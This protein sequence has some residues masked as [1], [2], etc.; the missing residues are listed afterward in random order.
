M[1]CACIRSQCKNGR[2][3]RKSGP[4][5]IDRAG[6]PDT[7]ID[8]GAS[9]LQENGDMLTMPLNQGLAPDSVS[10]PGRHGHE[11]KGPTSRCPE[12]QTSV[13]PIPGVM[14]S[15][16]LQCQRKR[17]ANR[18]RRQA[19][20]PLP[21]RSVN[22][23]IFGPSTNGTDIQEGSGASTQRRWPGGNSPRPAGLGEA[24]RPH[25]S[26]I[27]VPP[28]GGVEAKKMVAYTCSTCP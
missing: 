26:A 6:R 17:R 11:S 13:I 23:T 12:K 4:P 25:L 5:S 19:A 16:D 8:M 2:K 21:G 1:S 10:G 20:R 7:S 9:L 18:L 22:E 3:Q 24:A 27:G 15:I 14:W 28:S